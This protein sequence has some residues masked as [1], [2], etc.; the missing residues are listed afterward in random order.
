MSML[1][2]KLKK[3]RCYTM[4]NMNKPTAINSVSLNRYPANP[5]QNVLPV[6]LSVN[7][8]KWSASGDINVL[9]LRNHTLFFGK[10]SRLRFT[11][12]K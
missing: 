6:N 9:K 12:Q 2:L 4:I 11:F 3:E 1:V 7:G 10:T 8:V 5:K